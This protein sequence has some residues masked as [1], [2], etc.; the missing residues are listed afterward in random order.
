MPDRPFESSGVVELV[1]ISAVDLNKLC[2]RNQYGIKPSA[3]AGEGRGSRR[4]F[5][6]EDVLGI[7]LVWWL[8]EAGLRS[9]AIQYV[10]NQIAGKKGASAN[11]A[12][13]VLIQKSREMLVIERSPRTSSDRSRK[14]PKQQVHV[15]GK[16]WVADRVTETHAAPCMLIIQIHTLFSTIQK[17]MDSL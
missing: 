10:F 2:D 9:Q 5:T 3:R 11:T 6:R 1:G 14:F 13:Q 4:W 15:E 8:F 17:A 7:A 12:A 16:V